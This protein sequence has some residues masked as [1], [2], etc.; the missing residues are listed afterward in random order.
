M[1]LRTIRACLTGAACLTAAACTTGADAEKLK[2]FQATEQQVGAHLATFDDQDFNVFSA[3]KWDELAKSHGKDIAVHWPDGRLTVGLDAHIAD[4]KNMFVYAPD[5]HIREHPVKFGSGEWTTVVGVL[6]GTF[7]KPMLI[8]GGKSI[9]PTGRP[10]K[11]NM[12]TI[13]KWRDG[14]MVEKYLFWDNQ[15]FVL[16]I[17]LAK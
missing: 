11:L 9:A 12:T 7:T 16:Q 8:G 3:Q 2:Q 13:A 5:T 4:L 17:G 10:F 1:T 14:V 15:T 6:E